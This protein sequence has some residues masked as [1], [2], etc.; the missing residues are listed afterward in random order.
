M[1]SRSKGGWH[2]KAGRG[3]HTE[4]GGDYW[5]DPYKVLSDIFGPKSKPPKK[6]ALK[7]GKRF[8]NCKGKK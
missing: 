7:S 6:M 8:K 2:A 4:W 5:N 3:W 1:G